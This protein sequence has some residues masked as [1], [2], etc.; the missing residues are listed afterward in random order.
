[1]SILMN[2][3]RAQKWEDD[4][5]DDMDDED[6]FAEFDLPESPGKYQE[7]DAEDLEGEFFIDEDFNLSEENMNDDLEEDLFDEYEDEDL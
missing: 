1:M 2:Y 3:A 6:E 4:V 5:Y 7:L